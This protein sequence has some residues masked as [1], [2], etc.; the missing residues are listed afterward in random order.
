L[1]GRV[2]SRV[3]EFYQS[4]RLLCESGQNLML[5]LCLKKLPK[6]SVALRHETFRPYNHTLVN[7]GN[8]KR[9]RFDNNFKQSDAKAVVDSNKTEFPF[10]PVMVSKKAAQL[11]EAKSYEEAIVEYLKLIAMVPASPA[12]YVAIA[13]CFLATGDAN[14]ADQYVE[15]A[16]VINDLFV[17]AIL[18]KA[19][20]NIKTGNLIQANIFLEKAI[21]IEPDNIDA[22]LLLC[23]N[24]LF[25]TNFVKA[26]EIYEQILAI[27]PNNKEAHAG[28]GIIYYISNNYLSAYSEFLQAL[29]TEQ[30]NAD[31]LIKSASCLVL[32]Q[33]YDEAFQFIEKAIVVDPTHF[34]AYLTR[35]NIYAQRSNFK[36]AIEDFTRF[37]NENDT[38]AINLSPEN[39]LTHQKQKSDIL[40]ARSDCYIQ[41]YLIDNK[42]KE[43]S[44]YYDKL[45]KEVESK[46]LKEQAEQRELQQQAQKQIS[47]QQN[48]SQQQQK[49]QQQ[50]QKQMLNNKN[51]NQLKMNEE[52]SLSE[53]VD[54]NF[55][56]DLQHRIRVSYSDNFRHAFDDLC[57]ARA[58]HFE[59]KPV[60]DDQ[61]RILKRVVN[62]CLR[63]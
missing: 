22:R 53:H 54:E 43:I 20:I 5:S 48:Q 46:F 63:L 33:R 27:E 11:L 12:A 4:I 13:I 60:V 8:Q 61:L 2:Y 19:K 57:S 6:N 17:P 3:F 18:E 23:A 35:G 1:S 9:F 28:L 56:V 40:V 30:D 36:E 14:E 29:G 50:Q 7:F 55:M 49:Q 15:K 42:H 24:Y 47:Q 41:D 58:L 21:R 45:Q 37:M 51:R 32:L 52:D 31:L 39:L 10:S 26:Q 34:M 38:Y 62:E 59:S 25:F 16:L 44:S